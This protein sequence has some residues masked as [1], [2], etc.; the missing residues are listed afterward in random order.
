MSEDE[1]LN[2]RGPYAGGLARRE[3]ILDATVE[4][5][6][7]VGYHG[8]SLR[9]VA[10]RVGISHPGVIYH[11]PSKEALLMAVV[12]RFD[13]D[14]NFSIESLE[15]AEPMEI[16][17]RFVDITRS[18]RQS[19]IFVEMECMLAVEAS[20]DLHPAHDHFVHRFESI[21][22]I[23]TRAF[24]ELKNKDLL[25]IDVKPEDLARSLLSLWYGMHIQF[26]YFPK[27]IDTESIIVRVITAILDVLKP[28]AMQYALMLGMDSP[29]VMRSIM[30]GT[31][32]KMAD[33]WEM[34]MI[35]AN[36]EMLETVG[37][38]WVPFEI[39]QKLIDNGDWTAEHFSYYYEN[40]KL[41]PD[42]VRAAL[43]S[44]VLTT[45]D[46][47]AIMTSK[48]LPDEVMEL[49]RQAMLGALTS[50]KEDGKKKS[51]K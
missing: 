30:S 4:M 28:E 17:K 31:D 22:Q 1:K 37:L 15:S 21:N 49:V 48:D 29:E 2:E 47:A 13:E 42:V 27:Q 46:M 40:Q 12:Q 33:L 36:K 20:S 32:M 25:R 19:P 43:T 26:L 16:L 18:L 23:L 6:A 11:F 50:P 10:R 44:S 41:H 39:A 34:G 5:I 8:L 35:K 3:A 7:E 51:D 45:E 38:G 24:T 9:D 14:E